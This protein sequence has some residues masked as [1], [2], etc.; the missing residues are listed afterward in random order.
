[1]SILFS[2]LFHLPKLIIFCLF[3]KLVGT[4]IFKISIKNYVQGKE[5]APNDSSLPFKEKEK[6]GEGR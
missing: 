4:S 3:K 2:F 6:G 5:R 1:M